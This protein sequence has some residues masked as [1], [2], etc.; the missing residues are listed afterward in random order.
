MDAKTND[1]EGT[2][3]ISRLTENM[4]GLGAGKLLFAKTKAGYTLRITCLFCIKYIEN[5]MPKG[6]LRIGSAHVR[7]LGYDLLAAWRAFVREEGF[8]DKEFLWTIVQTEPPSERIPTGLWDTVK[9]SKLD[10]RVCPEC[11]NEFVYTGFR[12]ENDD[13]CAI[14]VKDLELQSKGD[15]RFY[16]MA[17]GHGI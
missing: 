5:D 15:A 13:C 3:V 8:K 9:V 11:E 12:G 17:Y 4:R 1:K 10:I 16:E 2:K 6:N 14:C 7:N